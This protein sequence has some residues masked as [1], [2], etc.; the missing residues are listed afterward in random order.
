[1]TEYDEKVLQQYEAIRASGATNMFNAIRVEE[2]AKQAGMT[3]LAEFIEEHTPSEYIEM[4]EES[5]EKYRE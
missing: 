3:E 5:A 2:Y 1:M 4:A